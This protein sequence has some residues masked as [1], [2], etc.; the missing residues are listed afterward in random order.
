MATNTAAHESRIWLLITEDCF[1][2]WSRPA[3][4]PWSPTR[5]QRCH[6]SP[7]SCRDKQT[8]SFIW[9]LDNVSRTP[10]WVKLTHI[11]HLYFHSVF[12]TY[13]M[14]SKYS[15][16]TAQMVTHRVGVPVRAQMTSVQVELRSGDKR[17]EVKWSHPSR[18]WCTSR[19]ISSRGRRSPPVRWTGTGLRWRARSNWTRRSN[20]R[21]SWRHGT[22]AAGRGAKLWAV[23]HVGANRENRIVF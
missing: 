9:R 12:F 16:S 1:L 19:S 5:W 13:P 2:P 11:Q 15:L 7:N 8:L 3:Q 17:S 4:V 20:G 6:S 21:K 23:L 22:P 14:S 10:T 18:W